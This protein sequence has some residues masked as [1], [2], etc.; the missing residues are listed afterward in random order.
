MKWIKNYEP[1]IRENYIEIHYKNMNK[2]TEDIIRYLESKKTLIGKNE[3]KSC[4]I[5]IDE[6]YYCE[7][8]D[9]K[10]YAYLKEEVWRLQEGLSE[11]TEQYEINGFIRISKS[12]IVNIYKVK[13]IE[14]D[15][16][17]RMNLVLIN[18]ETVVMSRNYRNDFFRKL[19]S[20]RMEEKNDK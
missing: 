5:N 17:M 8:V 7:I 14:A 15:F 6:I 9:R 20:F 16:N 4:F 18:G 3:T 19:K 11:L 1:D 2:E 12:M 10:C 13:K